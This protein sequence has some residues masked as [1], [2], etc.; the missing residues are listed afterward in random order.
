MYK[1]RIAENLT[2]A[3]VAPHARSDVLPT[4]L[5][6]L[7]DRLRKAHRLTAE[8]IG[9]ETRERMKNRHFTMA[10][11]TIALPAGDLQLCIPN[12][13]DGPPARAVVFLR[14]QETTHAAFVSRFGPGVPYSVDSSELASATTAYTTPSGTLYAT[15]A[16][17]TATLRVLTIERR[18]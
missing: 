12:G 2:R 3:F 7:V 11:G 10:E 16:L 15:F 13:A 14:G 5:V 8:A 4:D 9:I 1:P 6:A 17:D 18:A